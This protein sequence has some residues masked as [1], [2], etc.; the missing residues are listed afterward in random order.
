MRRGLTVTAATRQGSASPGTGGGEDEAG[1]AERKRD[2]EERRE[3][4]RETAAG[5]NAFVFAFTSARLAGNT[6]VRPNCHRARATGVPPSVR[7]EFLGNNVVNK[8]A[9]RGSARGHVTARSDFFDC[10]PSIFPAP[11]G[12]RRKARC[13]TRP[14]NLREVSR[15]TTPTAGRARMYA[16]TDALAHAFAHACR[17]ARRVQIQRR[18]KNTIAPDYFGVPGAHPAY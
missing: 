12:P 17:H 8:A 9:R 11:R 10:V 15:R 13:A 18:R 4:G 2:R 16:R 1:I 6:A 5:L 7:G 14:C 3:R